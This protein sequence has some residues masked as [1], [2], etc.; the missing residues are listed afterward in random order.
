MALRNARG[1]AKV[2]AGCRAEGILK[3]LQNSD[4]TGLSSSLK[5]YLAPLLGS[6]GT[7]KENNAENELHKLAKEFAPFILQFL[8]LCGTRLAS[9]QSSGDAACHAVADELFSSMAISLDCLGQLRLFLTGGSFEIEIQ[10]YG[11][12]RRLITWKKISSALVQCQILFRSLCQLSSATRTEKATIK[13]NTTGKTARSGGA[14]S[15]T[16]TETRSSEEFEVLCPPKV[17]GEADGLPALIVAAVIDLIWCSAE[18]ARGSLRCFERI[19]HL[20]EELAPWISLLDAGSAAKQRDALFRA[21]YKCTL[22]VVAQ[23]TQFGANLIKMLC[24]ITLDLCISSCQSNQYSKVARKFCTSLSGVGADGLSNAVVICSMALSDI[25]SKD[26]FEEVRSSM[27]VLELVDW[28]SRSCQSSNQIDYCWTQIFGFVCPGHQ[29]SSEIPVVIAGLYGIALMLMKLDAEH[30]QGTLEEVSHTNR[31]KKNGSRDTNRGSSVLD[32]ACFLLNCTGEVLNCIVQLDYS[33]ENG[34]LKGEAS[35]RAPSENWCNHLSRLRQGDEFLG[36]LFLGI[37]RALQ[38]LHKPAARYAQSVW[39]EYIAG[40]QDSVFSLY[41]NINNHLRRLLKLCYPL[42][43]AGMRCPRLSENDRDFLSKS[44]P[45]ASQLSVVALRFSLLLDDGVQDVFA[46]ISHGIR[47]LL[48]EEQS[49]LMSSTYN[50]GVQLFNSRQYSLACWP[51]ELAYKTAWARIDSALCSMKNDLSHSEMVAEACIKCS[52]FADAKSRNGEPGESKLILL[53]G[54]KQ[55]ARVQSLTS[56]LQAPY[57]LLKSLVK[58][59]CVEMKSSLGSICEGSGYSSLYGVLGAL[60]PPLPAETLGLLLEE[61]LAAC[62]ALGE[63]FPEQTRDLEAHIFAC[64][65]ENVYTRDTSTIAK[66]RL[67]LKKSRGARLRDSKNLPSSI[68]DVSEALCLMEAA[69]NSGKYSG[70]DSTEFCALEM[71]LAVANSMMAIYSYELNPFSKDFYK[72]LVQAVNTWKYLL[73]LTKDCSSFCDTKYPRFPMDQGE[74]PVVLLL[75]LMDLVHIK[76]YYVLLGDLHELILKVS[77]YLGQPVPVAE[78]LSSIMNRSTSHLLCA[79]L[80]P[81]EIMSHTRRFFD[82]SSEPLEYWQTNMGLYPGSMMEAQYLTLEDNADCSCGA[83]RETRV[84]AEEFQSVEKIKKMANFTTLDAQNSNEITLHSAG[85]RHI[86]AERFLQRGKLSEAFKYANEAYQLRSKLF[87]RVFRGFEKRYAQSVSDHSLPC[88]DEEVEVLAQRDVPSSLSASSWPF[89][90]K[91]QQYLGNPSHWRILGDYV[92][93]LRQVGVIY[94]KMGVADDAER[95]FREGLRIATAQNLPTVVSW[96]SSSLGE[97]Y[98]KRLV[99]ESAENHL[100]KAREAIEGLDGSAYCKNCIIRDKALLEMRIGDLIRHNWFYQQGQSSNSSTSCGLKIFLAENLTD[101]VSC[102]TVSTLTL[103][104]SLHG[105]YGIGLEE[106]DPS[107]SGPETKQRQIL[108]T[109]REHGKKVSNRIMAAVE[110]TPSRAS[111]RGRKPLLRSC[112][113]TRNS[114]LT[115]LGICES[116]DKDLEGLFEGLSLASLSGDDEKAAEPQRRKTRSAAKPVNG[117]TKGKAQCPEEDESCDRIPPKELLVRTKTTRRSTK[118]KKESVTNPADEADMLDA[119]LVDE[120]R[121]H[122]NQVMASRGIISAEDMPHHTWSHHIRKLLARVFLQRGKCLV[123]LGQLREAVEVYRSAVS[124]LYASCSACLLD[125]LACSSAPVEEGVVLY[126]MSR[127][128]LL[129]DQ[130]DESVRQRRRSC[131]PGCEELGIHK[132]ETINRLYR[133]YN[134]CN[135]VPPIL[136]KIAKLLA[137]LYVAL[138]HGNP[139]LKPGLISS[140]LE[141][142]ELAAYFHQISLGT[143]LRQQ[144][145]AALD[146]KASEKHL[147]SQ[148]SSRPSSS[149]CIYSMQRALRIVPLTAEN[150]GG[151]VREFLNSVPPLPVCCLSF[152]D[153]ADMNVVGGS[154]SSAKSNPRPSEFLL[155]TRFTHQSPPVVVLLPVEPL[156]PGRAEDMTGTASN[157]YCLSDDEETSSSE[158]ESSVPEELQSSTKKSQRMLEKVAAEFESVLEESRESTSAVHPIAT[159]HEKS[160]W[161]KWRMQLDRRLEVLVRTIERSWIGHHK[162]L[163]LGEPIESASTKSFDAVANHLVEM[164]V[165]VDLTESKC[166]NK[167]VNYNFVRSLLRGVDSYTDPQLQDAI[168]QILGWNNCYSV[169]PDADTESRVESSSVAPASIEGLKKLTGAFRAAFN[170]LYRTCED[171]TKKSIGEESSGKRIAR[172]QPRSQPGRKKKISAEV[173]PGICAENHKFSDAPVKR[174]PLQ[175]ILDSDAQALPWESLPILREHEI[176][177]MPSLGSVHA[178][179]IQH[180]FESI[181][182]SQLSRD[183]EPNRRKPA[184]NNSR[185]CNG[186]VVNRKTDLLL[187]VTFVNP[188]NTFY[189]LN[190]SGDLKSTQLSFEDWFEHQ[191]GWKG[192]AGTPPTADEFRKALQVYDLFVYLGHGTGDQF[193]PE[194]FVRQL[195][196]CAAALLMGCSS[197]RL[198][199]RGLYEPFGTV[200]SY[201]MAGCPSVIANLWDVTDGDIDR[202]S[203]FLLQKWMALDSE[204]AGK[205]KFRSVTEVQNTG[206]TLGTKAVQSLHAKDKDVFN[207]A[208]ITETVRLSSAIGRSREACRLPY[209]IGASPICYGVPTDSSR[210]VKYWNFTEGDFNTEKKVPNAGFLSSTQNVKGVELKAGGQ[211]M[212]PCC[213]DWLNESVFPAA[214][215]F[216][217]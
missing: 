11:L 34:N 205:D 189:I 196:Q 73:E 116:Q 185:T 210:T 8:K 153:E 25:S 55:W 23:P 152:V 39:N 77:A 89:T 61:E 71:L 101:A 97:V 72:F 29:V 22:V 44:F 40:S 126:H 15:K 139:L 27:E 123:H 193:L 111:T 99:W 142:V 120:G 70:K 141:P 183:L 129:M 9:M 186:A 86:I 4:L 30:S 62:K 154:W 169:T 127:L 217:K 1:Q 20:P 118:V 67:L 128:L 31:S 175:L 211:E 56:R 197:G 51:F 7:G 198:S 32:D 119:K 208:S 176:Y 6:Y 17:G 194:R 65:L 100:N 147:N 160:L 92:E 195:D 54:I 187:E 35:S 52:A 146:S 28:F 79:V 78:F 216:A 41:V 138:P 103:S 135:Q 114:T 69:L 132:L 190:P 203:K 18:D 215:G 21:L 98:R 207:G 184:G 38:Y 168:V 133:A 88:S 12:V 204:S 24:K 104:G 64:L 181:G 2:S 173:I 19:A 105:C 136:R 130:S 60:Q 59:V 26:E 50:M 81:P 49:W 43:E 91:V 121:C 87:K 177:R 96:F 161:W 172:K 83:K 46:S 213:T 155:L 202:F 167:T 149:D 156:Y 63:H 192:K 13:Q 108:S 134:L 106:K 151:H 201:L 188:C 157:P 140:G 214:A 166:S 76:G 84:G 58:L 33:A 163:L 170:G 171:C 162:C 200:L 16:E 80:F 191:P 90:V 37:T 145:L 148:L 68:K 53:D 112:V 164:L 209:L 182:E 122:T 150:I 174:Q 107:T 144:H 131:R 165:A 124:G 82:S 47:H 14:N 115:E 75:S 199:P 109:L 45:L 179:Y 93:S 143:T 48:P 10:R 102:Y 66:C 42:M 178:V 137:V 212:L 180:Q 125:E 95:F 85:L 158:G 3:L 94:E 206:E 110:E 74:E 159:A 57:A 117:L 36:R 113:K 5:T